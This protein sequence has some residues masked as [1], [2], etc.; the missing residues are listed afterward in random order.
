MNRL[1]RFLANDQHEMQQLLSHALDT[2]CLRRYTVG[3]IA[4]GP[5]FPLRPSG[6]MCL[7]T[8]ASLPPCV[9]WK[10]GDDALTVS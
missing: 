1:Y 10:G 6:G 9:L 8:P 2:A 5:S 4:F 3:R 7:S